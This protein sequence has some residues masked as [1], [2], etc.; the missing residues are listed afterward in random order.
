MKYEN[1]FDEIAEQYYNAI[2]RYCCVKMNNEHAAKDC[3]QE[4]F[5]I[6]FTKMDNL[7]LSENIRAWLYRTADRVMSNYR[8]KHKEMVSY[9]DVN[10]VTEDTYSVEIPFNDI[11]SKDEYELLKSYYIDGDD[12]EVI[13]VRLGI[14]TAAVAQRIHRIKSKI[15]NKYI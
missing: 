14:S 11:I 15:K 4:V 13:S 5:L 1:I 9:D 7:K 10:V 2:F 8:K 3:T 12:I 6:F